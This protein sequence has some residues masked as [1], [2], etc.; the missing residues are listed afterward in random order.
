MLSYENRKMTTITTNADLR[1]AATVLRDAFALYP[2]MRGVGIGIK[3]DKPCLR[4]TV[5]SQTDLLHKMPIVVAGVPVLVFDVSEAP[6]PVEQRPITDI[7]LHL[8]SEHAVGDVL[9]M[10]EDV[11]ENLHKDLHEGG[12]A[13]DLSWDYGQAYEALKAYRDSRG[14]GFDPANILEQYFHHR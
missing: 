4:V 14:S 3:N 8:L 11:A 1:F 6:L 5:T 10:P 7:R 13:S 12:D 9:W 2:E